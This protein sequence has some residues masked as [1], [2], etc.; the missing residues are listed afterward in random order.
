MSCPFI[1]LL[2][3]E[4]LEYQLLAGVR[5]LLENSIAVKGPASAWD[6]SQSYTAPALNGTFRKLGYP[7][8][9]VLIIRIL[10]ARVTIFGSPIFGNPR[11]LAP[12]RTKGLVRLS[13]LGEGGGLTAQA[14]YV[15]YNN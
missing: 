13:Q 7:N 1:S 15:S 14:S 10:L 2:R 4:Q 8:F 5:D 12:N 6:C 3:V 11:I 9:G